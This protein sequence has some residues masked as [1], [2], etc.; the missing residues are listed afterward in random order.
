MSNEEQKYHEL[1]G[2]LSAAGFLLMADGDARA[3]LVGV[4]LQ[5]AGDLL[6]AN[7][8]ALA[9]Q[10]AG[11]PVHEVVGLVSAETVGSYVGAQL[12]FAVGSSIARLVFIGAFDALIVTNPI[13]AGLV[14]A[15]YCATILGTVI[16]GG[17]IGGDYA[18]GLWIKIFGENSPLLQLL[19]DPLILDLNGDGITLSSLSASEVVFD[20]D[21]DGFAERTGWVSADDGILV[22]DA[23]ANGS[24]D[25][26][27]ELFGSPTQDGFA[28]LER[29]DSNRDGKIDA[30]DEVFSSLR[31]WRDLNQNGVADAGEL[32]TLGEAGIASISLQ[33]TD[34]P[35]T[36]NG[37]TLGYGSTFTKT[38]GTTGTAQTVYFETDR[39][40]T[41]AAEPP[42][43]E[44][45]AEAKT[46]PQLPGSGQIHSIA[47]AVTNDSAFM[48]KWAALADESLRLS[49]DELRGRFTELLLEWAD[50][51][52]VLNGGR[53]PFVDAQHLTF[54]EKFFGTGY[55][56][57]TGGQEVATSPSNAQLAAQIE[58]SFQEI[59][60]ALLTVYLSQVG[61]SSLLRGGTL[62]AVI[63]SPYFAYALLD[64][65]EDA[66]PSAF[67]NVP[68]VVELLT[69]LAPEEAGAR[70]E[71]LSRAFSGLDGVASIAFGGDRQAYLQ[72]VQTAIASI[73]EPQLHQ[74]VAAIVNGQAAIGGTGD[75]GLVLL[76]GSNHFDGGQGDDVIV[77]GAGS[78]TFIYRSG[79]GSDVIRDSAVSQVDEDTLIFTDFHLSDLQ[80][81]RLGE[82]LQIRIA[83]SDDVISVEK[84][85][86]NWE[87]ENRGID[88]IVF[89]DGTT[90]SRQ[91]IGS[92]SVSVGTAG[93]N[94]INDT[95]GDDLIKAGEGDDEIVISEGNDT[96]T[97]AVGDG[98]DQI[99]D[100]SGSATE[101]DTL[102]LLGLNPDDVE[103]TRIGEHLQV[104]VKQT[105]ETIVSSDFFK[106][107]TEAGSIG[108]WGIDKIEFQ[109]GIVWT[110][111]DI[112]SMAVIRGT[113]AAE[114]LGGGATA[115]QLRGDGG[116]DTL[117]GGKGSDAYHW[118]VGDGSD[119]ISEGD[120]AGTD[121]L[122]LEGLRS[123]DVEL[124]RRGTSLLIHVKAS[125]EVIEVSNQ[126]AEVGN[127]VLDWDKT[128]NGLEQIRF[129][130]GV[131]WDRQ[132]IMRSIVT[133][134]FDL[135]IKYR[136]QFF[137]EQGD[138][139]QNVEVESLGAALSEVQNGSGPGAGGGTAI[140][141]GITFTDELGR[142]GLFYDI[143]SFSQAYT[144]VTSTSRDILFGDEADE[145][146]GPTYFNP[147]S[148]LPPTSVGSG[149]GD[150]GGSSSIPTWPGQLNTEGHNYFDGRGGNDRIIGGGGHDVLIGGTGNDELFGDLESESGN[151]GSGHD[152]LD[153]GEGND[154]LFGGGGNDYLDGGKGNDLISGGAG[155]D[156]LAEYGTSNNS[157]DIFDGGTGD[158]LI[159]S[160]YY[161]GDSGSD[162]FLY[163]RGDGSDR[164]V[165]V[166]ATSAEVDILKLVDMSRDDVRLARDGYDLIVKVL[167]TGETITSIDFFSSSQQA[168]T[169]I[170]K[171]E[172]S[173]G[174]SLNRQDIW[175]DAWFRGTD[176]RDV[177]S[178]TS[179]AG[180]TFIGYGGDDVLVSAWYGSSHNGEDTFVYSSG[181][182]NDVI[183][184]HCVQ[185]GEVDT[186]WLTD[187]NANDVE[188]TRSD[189]DLL[190]KDLKT[191]QIITAVDVVRGYGYGIDAIKFADGSVWDRTAILEAAWLRGSVT[192]DTLISS[193]YGR[194]T[195]VGGAGDDILISGSSLTGVTLNNGDDSFIYTRGDGN[196]V[197]AENSLSKYE[198]DTLYLR[199]FQQNEL[200]LTLENGGIRFT[201][202][203]S[204]G[205]ILDYAHSNGLYDL[206]LDRIVFDDGSEWSKS[207]IYYWS[208]QGSAFYAGGG[209]ADTI[210]GSFLD[211]RLSG[212]G[213]ADFID[214]R[215]GSDIVFGDAGDDVLALSQSNEGDTDTLNGGDGN[216][217]LSFVDFGSS[218]F[219]DL[220]LNGGEAR[221]SVSGTPISSGDRLIATL[222]GLENVQGTAFDDVI[223]GD[224]GANRLRGEGGNDTLDGRS[225]NDTLE[226]GD[227]DDTLLGYLGNDT[228]DGG[229]GDDILQ[230]DLGN[231]S[232]R[233]GTGSDRIEGGSG[234]DTYNYAVGDGLDV[235]VESVDG[236]QD[237]L[238][239]QGV[240]P[241]E[242]Q[243][244]VTD[245]GLL[246][247]R[248]ASA[249]DQILIQRTGGSLSYE[250]F[251]IERI[252]FDGGVE[253]SADFLRQK[254]I[255]DSA[256]DGADL[257]IGTSASGEMKGGRGDDTLDGAGG[258]DTFVYAR[259]DG[260]DTISEI[261]D[262]RG[263][264]DQL[265]FTN[266]NPGDVTLVR[267]G[268]DLTIVIAE[269]APG[270]G[271]AGS[272]LIKSTL[273]S[274]R[275]RGIEKITFADGTVWT[276][277]QVR[278]MV[279]DQAGTAGNDAI[280]GLNTNDTLTGRGGNDTL[281]GGEGND[282]FVYARG[283]GND[284]IS[285]ITDYRGT[286]DQLVFTNINPGDVTLVRNGVDLTIVIAESAPGA[287]DA[288]SVLIKST[289]DS[290]RERG[291]EKITFADG[292]VWTI[293]QVRQMVIDQAGTVGNDTI[294]GLNTND[295]LTGRGGNDT[296]DGGEGNDTFVYARGDGNDTISEITDYRGTADQLVFTN[297]NPGDVTLV[298]NGVDLTIVIA[299][300]APGAGDAGSVL[301]KSTLDSYR[302]R[303]IEKI[304]FADGTAWNRTAM[305]ANVEFVG[306][307]DGNETITGTSG[308]DRVLAGLGNDTITT[309]GGNDTIVFRADFGKD[310][311]TDFQ[312]GAG[313]LDVIE[314]ANSLFTD[315]E[316]VLASAAQV[317]ND[318][319]ITYDAQNT[320]T[321]KNV[322]LTSLHQDDFRFVA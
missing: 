261:T 268:V 95:D 45:S 237:T 221:T 109:N 181:E 213:G 9:A 136:V 63:T 198:I 312:A 3:R 151:S 250:Q 227:G 298:R 282:T 128:D 196:D 133:A 165:E 202:S 38:D 243:L 41:S 285:E 60:D 155:A 65:S 11:R 80:F 86:R 121:A 306:G 83:G 112:A 74:M 8:T 106:A 107:G 218:V 37:H 144:L 64:F 14:V 217:T 212:G 182:G 141:A 223:A 59:V 158:D 172:F 43:F 70:A 276:I 273:D 89:A 214:G 87:T 130:N 274:Y 159:V 258:N 180:N 246:V 228:L 305:N 270:A 209:S 138:P 66:P 167:S 44:P 94:L 49:F 211:Q 132:T 293:A 31:V 301:I 10:H 93:N 283:D 100:E 127:I 27:S 55:R 191:G 281:D 296:L 169:G 48:A 264:A 76:D 178:T 101:A 289:L 199:G 247:T 129:A 50:V 7:S 1:G 253:W 153:G 280:T 313:S 303:G 309:S 260:N 57:L 36:S 300:S 72:A 185:E 82:T 68:A 206:G 35:G 231:D 188:L 194:Q 240:L 56:E 77:S 154:R 232:L 123:G 229:D 256:T 316:D 207:D 139:L 160:G 124:L 40:D 269:S 292:T 122:V 205:S 241:A 54:V 210:L 99:V 170:D 24:V 189:R 18:E 307:T 75:D 46:L 147:K 134:G 171:I 287:G 187:L 23:N 311:I 290:Y 148:T 125:G 105:G 302:E 17:Y 288:G 235:I 32:M 179:E 143:D 149:N 257:L 248:N 96:I 146:I 161:V 197:I 262:Y 116:N 295:T 314:L 52:G 20:F 277:A 142:S 317:G 320:I 315:F 98:N 233:G 294:T 126:F 119:T 168:G 271:D 291:I 201:F 29:L 102:K 164:I 224:A 319:L 265:V 42:G 272:V 108:A 53:G 104:L 190:I 47:F 175:Q 304:T 254:F 308:N 16:A 25:G 239:L 150:G 51:D 79:D 131:V 195:F 174:S 2:V 15:A 297:I 177:I 91:E 321:L 26:A 275:E 69:A 97:Y 284:T 115:D 67:R 111:V 85:F 4:G 145:T 5:A 88:K 215:A 73:E 140:I 208:H 286:A 251:G 279:I 12:G 216:D 81:E 156:V 267:N 152:T 183:E 234:D 222:N 162:T 245:D 184:D 192:K 193:S 78:D 230:G 117:V 118:S 249:G 266:I 103:L 120:D 263:T 33:T 19:R 90:L 259:G 157:D 255:S 322:A 34:V 299:E 137:N 225:G 220:V 278:Q 28:V 200:R 244:V 71:Y 318:T 204:S 166:S 176:G 114:T 22:R 219:V 163:R 226:G 173:D 84:F 21:G 58:G 92:L 236:G 242:V 110:K 113:D 186:L 62:E 30:Q 203:T 238:R 252:V 135:D 61:S 39:Q 6:S 310:S 13:L